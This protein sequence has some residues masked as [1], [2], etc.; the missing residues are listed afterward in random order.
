MSTLIVLSSITVR[1][2]LSDDLNKKF[3]INGSKIRIKLTLNFVLKL[4]LFSV[5]TM[6]KGKFS[7][8]D[9]AFANGNNSQTALEIY[10]CLSIVYCT[11]IETF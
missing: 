7:F 3:K 5:A 8:S 11:Q 10:G 6:L 1:F 9:Q 4:F 2:I